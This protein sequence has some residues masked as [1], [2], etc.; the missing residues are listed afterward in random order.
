MCK[1]FM[2]TIQKRQHLFKE[3]RDIPYHIATDGEADASCAT[4]SFMLQR[5]LASLGIGSVFAYGTFSW[6][7]LNLPVELIDLL[8]NDEG[9]HQWL[10]VFIPETGVWIDLDA[11]WDSGLQEIL[12]I[13]AWDGLN[14]TGIAVP[15]Q[16]RCSD[17]E[18][19]LITSSGYKPREVERYMQEFRPF[20]LS[21]N[22]YLV[23]VRG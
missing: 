11:S 3:V 15:I 18:N 9:W 1:E 14:S 8:P 22:K 19:A 5:R 6:R 20:L 7:Q 13:A 2:N 4:K 17:E 21:L 12:P 23:K 10:R 16:R